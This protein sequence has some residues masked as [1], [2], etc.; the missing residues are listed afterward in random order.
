MRQAQE[1]H[2]GTLCLADREGRLARSATTVNGPT[3]LPK[4]SERKQ[5][6]A[7]PQTLKPHR[8]LAQQAALGSGARQTCRDVRANLSDPLKMQILTGRPRESAFLQNS[9]GM[10]LLPVVPRATLGQTRVY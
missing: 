10:L 4:V 6:E 2:H 9:Q 3:K 1:G 5:E 8:L 7:P